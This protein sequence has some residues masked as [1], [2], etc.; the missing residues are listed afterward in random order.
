MAKVR[1]G[2]K[3]I[4]IELDIIDVS[5][6]RTKTPVKT[7]ALRDNFDIDIDGNII[8]L[9]DYAPLVEFGTDDRPGAFMATRS[10]DEIGERLAKRIAEQI[11]Q[12]GLIVLPEIT[13]KVGG[14][15]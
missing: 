8:N 13:L 14:G 6:I 12:P 5:I 10:L 4:D 11:N 7:G 15:Q 9:L 2:N 1:V 3:I